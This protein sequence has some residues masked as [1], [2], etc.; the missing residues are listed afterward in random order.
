MTTPPPLSG[1]LHR[2]LTTLYREDILQLQTL[3]DKDL[4]HWLVN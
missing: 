4:S 1:E 3:I 2:E